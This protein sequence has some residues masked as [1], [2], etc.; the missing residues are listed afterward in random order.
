MTPIDLNSLT[1][2]SLVSIESFLWVVS[3]ALLVIRLKI[4][5]RG[6]RCNARVDLTGRVA[7]ITGAGQGIGKATM[8]ELLKSG[9]T[10]VFGDRDRRLA[11]ATVKKFKAKYEGRV[12]YIHLDLSDC[13][14]VRSFS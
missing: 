5:C 13:E 3:L 8:E 9:C 2:W 10:V 14:S 4:Y 11:E 12:Q 7:V 6:G 1:P